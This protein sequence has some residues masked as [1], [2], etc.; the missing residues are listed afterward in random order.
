MII[1]VILGRVKSTLKIDNDKISRPFV[2]NQN[3]YII[4]EN[5]IIRLN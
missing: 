3:L 4:K 5:S 1:D 2:L